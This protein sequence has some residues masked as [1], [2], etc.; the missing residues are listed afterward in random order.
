[1][2][3]QITQT[4]WTWG[5]PETLILT[6]TNHI[7][8][9]SS[10]KPK[11]ICSNLKALINS[12]N[13]RLQIWL[14]WNWKRRKEFVAIVVC[15]QNPNSKRQVPSHTRPFPARH[16][17]LINR[18]CECKFSMY[19]ACKPHIIPLPLWCLTPYQSQN[20]IITKQPSI[21]TTNAKFEVNK[22][23]VLSH[24]KS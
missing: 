1:M 9:T 8:V 13:N 17:R 3:K 7:Y 2:W 4:T 15:A 16:W 21:S 11:L 10:L 6:N 12:A 19:Q 5:Q 18:T 22:K 24:E 23:F 14:K 20:Y